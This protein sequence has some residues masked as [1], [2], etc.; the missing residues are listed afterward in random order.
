MG[1]LSAA[2]KLDTIG[3]AVWAAEVLPGGAIDVGVA[4]DRFTQPDA[5]AYDLIRQ[6]PNLPPVIDGSPMPDAVLTLAV[7]AAFGSAP[8]RFVGI[9]NLRVK[10]CDRITAMAT[11]L[12][13]LCPGL[14]VENGDDLLVTPTGQ[15]RFRPARIET[16]SDHRIAVSMALAGLRVPGRDHPRPGLREQDL[17]RL[18]AD[19]A[20]LGAA[21]ETANG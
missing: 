12:S 10:E 21:M 2:C 1:I 11:E 6:F 20:S 17:P 9:A 7:L 16:Y 8:V 4:A 14:V 5:H 13:R 19:M 15:D 18:L 3:A